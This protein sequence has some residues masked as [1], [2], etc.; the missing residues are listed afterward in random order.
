[1]TN[2][3]IRLEARLLWRSFTDA[4]ST[5]SDRLLLM[6]V[7]VI[8]AFW[9]R[10]HLAEP[11]S[12]ALPTRAAWAG[13][14]GL[15]AGMAAQWRLGGRLAWLAEESPFSATA[16]QGL[17]RRTYLASFHGLFACGLAA[18]AVWIGVA[19]GEP[20]VVPIIALTNYAVG[21][22]LGAAC[23]REGKVRRVTT[24]RARPA[25]PR[26]SKA[27]ASRALIGVIVAHQTRDRADP[28]R[29]ATLLLGFVFVATL[30]SVPMSA[31]WTSPARIAAEAAPGL[32]ALLWTNRMDVRLV[33]FL[34]SLGYGPAMTGLAVSALPLACVVIAI[35]AVA[36]ARAPFGFVG[37]GIVAA[38]GAGFVL[39]AL[40]RTWLSPGRSRH[41]VDLQVGIES[42]IVL[43]VAFALPPLAPIMIVGR[44]AMLYR[45]A[46]SLRWIQR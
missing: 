3:L 6:M 19:V 18:A 14:A 4:F 11:M 1:M 20:I 5:A 28:V 15:P 26:P 31:A 10:T 46:A 34:P 24:R 9:V 42:A 12:F 40:G 27:T 32:F 44:L 35:L 30:G 45:R 29:G 39:V 25:N 43:L 8:A 33:G 2:R 17:A 22:A 7:A 21:T 36:A 13:L 41:S 23:R 37:S 38:A 16:R